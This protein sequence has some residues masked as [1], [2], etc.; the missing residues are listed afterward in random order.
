MRLEGV[1]STNKSPDTP[2]YFEDLMLCFG[3][4]SWMQA[5]FH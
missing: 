1:S 2:L 4:W 5:L 3:H